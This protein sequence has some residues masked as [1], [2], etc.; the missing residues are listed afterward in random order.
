MDGFDDLLAPTRDA[1][2]RNPFADPFGRPNSP[3]PWK[4]FHDADEDP[5]TAVSGVE[6][7]STTTPTLE[8]PGFSA[9]TT[10][11]T[12]ESHTSSQ[13]PLDSAKALQSDEDEPSHPHE[14]R[15]STPTDAP[16]STPKSPGFR[17]SVSTAIDDVLQPAPSAYV[18]EQ[19]TP[20][21]APS[22]PLT[23]AVGEPLTPA[24]P[25][26]T[27]PTE[28]SAFSSASAIGHVPDSS[29]SPYVS[30]SFPSFAQATAKPFHS[31]LDQPPSLDRSFSGLALGGESINGWQSMGQGS[32]NMFVGD[33]SQRSNVTNDDDDDDDD[34]PILQARMSSLE[35]AQRSGSPSIPVSMRCPKLIDTIVNECFRLPDN[36]T[37]EEYIPLRCRDCAC[38]YHKCR[39][40]T[41]RR[42]SY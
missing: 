34:K 5:A 11:T 17:E 32:Q 14:R 25:P 42:R 1:L 19:P 3:D 2:E 20:P 40:P 31:P 12:F 28:S 36:S 35:R 37:T 23:V 21:R 41:T 26:P 7:R 8:D 22:P 33:T 18:E 13:D 24:S 30:P 29:T 4:S 6:E 39:R 38:V 27:S 9:S 16:L 10:D 15:P